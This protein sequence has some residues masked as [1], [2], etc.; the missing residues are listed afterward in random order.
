MSSGGWD[1]PS[2]RPIIIQIGENESRRYLRLG[3]EF[4]EAAR[5]ASG[6]LSAAGV[7]PLTRGVSTRFRSRAIYVRG[8]AAVPGR[9]TSP[10]RR[11]MCRELAACVMATAGSLRSPDRDR[12]IRSFRRAL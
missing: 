2:G 12:R 8:E 10:T 9:R 6:Q 7:R 5:E 4:V 11:Y 1:G 3:F